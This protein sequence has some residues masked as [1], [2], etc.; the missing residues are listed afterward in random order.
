MPIAKPEE[1]GE[2]GGLLDRL[3]EKYQDTREVLNVQA[4]L[5]ALKETVEAGIDHITTLMIVFLLQTVVLPLL[6]L[7]GL[8]RLAGLLFRPGRD[9]GPSLL[10]LPQGRTPETA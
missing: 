7:W 6:V 4:R 9:G 3:R 2:K 10:R 5:E 8:V 1:P